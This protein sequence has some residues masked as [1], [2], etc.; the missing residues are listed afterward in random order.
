[1]P[2]RPARHRYCRCGTR[3]AADT[4][5][6][7]APAASTPPAI[8]SSP[9]PKYRTSSGRP[10]S[11]TTPSPPSTSAGSRGPTARTPHHAVYG[12]GGI[13][14]TLLWSHLS[15]YRHEPLVQEFSEQARELLA[16]RRGVWIS[17]GRAP[18][19]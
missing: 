18:G 14:Q 1:M 17:S 6:S 12:P 9:R 13:S 5:A 8:S 15:P 19:E 16:P 2:S 3:L 10:S 7:S 4:P 11:S